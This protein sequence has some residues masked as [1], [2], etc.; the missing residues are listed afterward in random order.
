MKIR[1]LFLISINN[2][3]IWVVFKCLY[4]HLLMAFFSFMRELFY[5]MVIDLFF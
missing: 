2:E 5:R 3:Q 1:V 4:D